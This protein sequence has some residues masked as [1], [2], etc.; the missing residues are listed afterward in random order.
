ME[1]KY[2]Y[3]AF[4][5]YTHADLDKFVAENLHKELEK[6]H[7]PKALAK[8]RP[9]KKN[10]IERVFRDKEELPSTSDMNDTIM[11][12]LHDS[13]HLIVI[14]SPRLRE[15]VW[16]KKEVETF[17]ELRGRENIMAVLV[18]GEPAESF[19]EALLFH[20]EKK[21]TK[22]GGIEEIKIPREHFAADVRG[23]NKR[24]V[25]KLIPREVQRLCAGMF[26]VDFDD[27][28]QRHK[29]Q[30]MRRTLLLSTIIGAVFFVVG[31][32]S[33]FMAIHIHNQNRELEALSA[34]VQSNAEQIMQQ[35]RELAYKQALS[36]AEDAERYLEEGNCQKAISTAVESLTESDGVELPYTPEGQYVLCESLR[37]YDIGV[38]ARSDYQVEVKGCI[39]EIKQSPNKEILAILDDTKTITLFDLKKRQL[40]TVIALQLYGSGNEYG[41]TFLGN[42]RFAYINS[43]NVICIL[44]LETKETVKEIELNTAMTLTSDEEGKYLVVQRWDDTFVVLDGTTYEEIGVTPDEQKELYMSLPYISSEGI[45]AFGYADEQEEYDLCFM[46]L[47][48]MERMSS[49]ELGHQKAK[50]IKIKDDVAYVALG[51]FEDK[52]TEVAAVAAAVDIQSGKI[53]WETAVDEDVRAD[54]IVIPMSNSGTEL[55]F[56]TNESV[57]R[58]NMQTGEISFTSFVNDEVADTVVYSEPCDYMILLKNG[59]MIYVGNDLNMTIDMG[60]RFDCKTTDNSHVFYTVHGIAVAENDAH[61]ITVYTNQKGPEIKETDREVV[62]PADEETLSGKDA[63]SVATS[64]GLE[65]AEYVRK[66]YYDPDKKYCFVTYM[67][68]SFIVYDVKKEQIIYSGDSAR[69]TELC[70][71]TD[72]EGYTYLAG[73]YGIYVL[74]EDMCPVMWIEHAKD[75]DME[76]K[77][78][79]LS[80]NGKYYEAPLYTVEELLDIAGQQ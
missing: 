16:C 39:K 22:D 38:T 11:A 58:I 7:L 79:Y 48:T 31:L 69:D 51:K 44:N 50:D 14:C 78:V 45:M 8:K 54:E 32:Y 1:R 24:A 2:K 42:D 75:V 29:E 57:S 53:M 74:N 73:V 9:G 28:R 15:S 37:V 80:W 67:D 3:D 61:V 47:N 46:D 76:N 35:N 19:P 66:V 21:E 49:L 63:E 13:E 56:A 27:I 25:K 70:L 5:S 17:L 52:Y 12:A 72:S 68:D 20:I 43:S 77:K 60:Y 55:L 4:I 33:T 23:K 30:K 36:L 34:E 65:D 26:H 62:L 59:E 40:V 64:Y 71:G 10:R 41:F 18:E 6:F